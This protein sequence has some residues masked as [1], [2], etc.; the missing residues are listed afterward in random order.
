[1]RRIGVILD[2]KS[3]DFSI[4]SKKKYNGDAIYRQVEDIW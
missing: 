1:M 4:A 3:V 2:E